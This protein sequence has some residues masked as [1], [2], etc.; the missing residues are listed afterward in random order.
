VFEDYGGGN[1]CPVDSGTVTIFD[2]IND[3]ADSAVVVPIHNGAGRY[4]THANTPNIF[5]GR[6]DSNGHN[7]DYQK[8]ITAIA[9][10]E[11]QAPVS[12]TEWV[13]VTGH[14]PRT[15]TFTG[16]SEG[17]PLLI[18]GPARRRIV[19]VHGART[20][21]LHFPLGL[22]EGDKHKRRGVESQSRN[23]IRGWH[24]LHSRDEGDHDC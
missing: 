17:I 8:S 19:R 1:L 9:E 23:R 14:R 15:A 3:T 6:I 2:E 13:L 16:L 10:V 11:G 12:A 22:V 20:E 7:R 21:F 4:V 18:L 5:T 24:R